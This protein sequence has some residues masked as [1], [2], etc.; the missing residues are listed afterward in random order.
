MT[1]RTLLIGSL[2]LLLSAC[3]SP[4]KLPE[5]KTYNLSFPSNQGA[6]INT[7][8]MPIRLLPVTIATPY[9]KRNFVYRQG[10]HEYTTAPYQQFIS[11]PSDLFTQYFTQA[12]NA[13]KNVAVLG[14]SALEDSDYT[15]QLQV[16]ALYADYQ[17]PKSP[18]AI[19][20][21]TAYL[22]QKEKGN[23]RLLKQQSFAY[24]TPI[25]TNDPDS[26]VNGYQKN[27]QAIAGKLEGFLRA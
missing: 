7:H 3:L 14:V 1:N 9:A 19:T 11:S 12:L 13:S 16:T 2:C 4:Q 27:L 8:K 17:H 5:T 22:Y 18:H 6:Q 15:L 20:K 21:L 10:T 23:M 25:Q 24:Q 26:L